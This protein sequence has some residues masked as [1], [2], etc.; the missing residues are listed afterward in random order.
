MCVQVIIVLNA[1]FIWLTLC[2][3]NICAVSQ[4]SVPHSTH[5]SIVQ[6]HVVQCI[7]YSNGVCMSG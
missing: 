3:V 4:V 5:I 2:V 1:V 7:M 6:Y